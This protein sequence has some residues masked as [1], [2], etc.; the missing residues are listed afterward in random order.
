M[1]FLILQHTLGKASGDKGRA[2]VRVKGKVV[3]ADS[4]GIAIS[5]ESGYKIT[6]LE[7]N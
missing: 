6:A 7:S 3:R 1:E 5:F 2:K 4:D